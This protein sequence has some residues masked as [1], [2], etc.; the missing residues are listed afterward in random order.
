MRAAA[1]ISLVISLTACAGEAPTSNPP[2]AK[3]TVETAAAS[4]PTVSASVSPVATA[5]APPGPAAMPIKIEGSKL[6][7]PEDRCRGEVDYRGRVRFQQID[8]M[9]QVR[10]ES[11]PLE[12][13]SDRGEK[14]TDGRWELPLPPLDKTF[15]TR[16][17][18]DLIL[19]D[20]ITTLLSSSDEPG[21]S[22]TLE[23]HFPDG[24][25]AR[26]VISLTDRAVRLG[27][28]DWM[29]EVRKGPLTLTGEADYTG[30]PR[31]MWV[32]FPSGVRGSARSA[33]ELDWVLVFD[34]VP[35]ELDC[36][37]KKKGR[38]ERASFTIQDVHGRVFERQSG[39]LIGEKTLPDAGAPTCSDFFH[40][41]DE[42]IMGAL[43]MRDKTTF[44][45][46]ADWAWGPL[47]AGTP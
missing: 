2:Q 25:L 3:P 33:T 12:G 9:T 5:S 35:R 26:G 6:R 20:D 41:R 30:A 23:L 19:P 13:L 18:A 44:I 31:A 16:P 17:I 27:F 21:V 29:R 22:L 38:V 45:Q 28:E 46:L 1:P 39:K 40:W 10:W 37:R 11:G 8:P 14:A 43:G 15:A 7:C 36:Q 4:A 34:D 42:N 32:E 47:R 24:A